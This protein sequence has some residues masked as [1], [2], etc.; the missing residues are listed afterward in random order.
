MIQPEKEMTA[1]FPKDDDKQDV[2]QDEENID[3]QNKRFDDQAQSTAS[4]VGELNAS[5]SYL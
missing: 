2:K 4:M 5:P 1:G 3:I